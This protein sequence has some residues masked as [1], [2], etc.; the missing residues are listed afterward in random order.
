MEKNVYSPS[1]SS[2]IEI[3]TSLSIYL[4]F[5]EY[6]LNRTKSPFKLNDADATT[7]YYK[8]YIN[9]ISFLIRR[10]ISISKCICSHT[11]FFYVSVNYFLSSADHIDCYSAVVSGCRAVFIVVSIIFLIQWHIYVT[12]SPQ[13]NILLVSDNKCLH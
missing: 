9:H 3:P 5:Q 13:S 12:F 4:N 11:Y 7:L 2:I 6:S 10:F 1:I 8:S